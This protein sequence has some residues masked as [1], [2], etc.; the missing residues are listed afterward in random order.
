MNKNH[1]RVGNG[2]QWELTCQSQGC[3]QQNLPPHSSH[4]HA[5][6][7]DI[8]SESWP[9]LLLVVLFYSEIIGLILEKLGRYDHF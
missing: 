4:A 7:I 2:S 6:K 9:S 3:P 1:S 8:W 5:L